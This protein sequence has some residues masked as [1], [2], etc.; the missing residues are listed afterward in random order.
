MR[1]DTNEKEFFLRLSKARSKDFAR[2]LVIS[3]IVLIKS[4]SFQQE[5]TLRLFNIM[6]L[7]GNQNFFFY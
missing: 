6:V 3:A 7:F 4:T 2:Y 5:K 1:P